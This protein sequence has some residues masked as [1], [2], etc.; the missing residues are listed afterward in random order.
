M[1]ARLPWLRAVQFLLSAVLLTSPVALQAQG[2]TTSSLNG[3]VTSTEGAA[4]AEAI[5]VAVHLP[6]GTVYRATARTGGAYSIPNM[7]VGGPYKVTV[8]SIGFEPKVEDNVFLS[9]G[10]AFRLDFRMIRRAVQLA[11]LTT[12]AVRD[13]VLNAGRSGATTFIDPTKVALLPSIKR[14]TRDLTRLDPRSD[15]NYSFAGRNWLYNNITLDGSYFNN[16]F[17]LDDPSP[18]GQ[19][20]AEPVPFDAIDQVHVSI[21]PFDVRQGG[22]TGANVNMVTKSG[23]NELHGTVS[24]FYRNDALQGNTVR[25]SSVIANPDLKYLQ[26]GFSA[27]GPIQRD[28]LFFFVAAELQRNRDPGSNFVASRGSTGF[29]IS[30]VQASVMDAIRQ[31][32]ITEYDYDPGPYEGYQFH[33]DNDKILAK[34]DWNL[35]ENTN[36]SFRYNYLSASRD[37]GPH[38][39]VLSVNNT[40]RGPNASSLPFYKSG[41]AI[42]NKLNSFALELNSRSTRYANRFFASYNRFRDFRSP[43]SE[44]F[45]T[46][47]I[48]EAGVT[49]TTAGSEPFSIHN[50]LD[51]DVFQVTN[52]FTVFR[53]KHTLTFG[54]NFEQFKFFNSFNIFRNGVFFLPQFIPVGSTFSSVSEFFS[55]TAPGPNQKDFRG[56]IGSGPFKGEKISVG[57]LS[58]YVEDELP[59]SARLN[60][61]FG[62]RV[63]LPM[64]FTDPVDNAYTR[65]LTALDENRQPETVDQ[66]RLPGTKAL[67]SP[68]IG[69]NWNAAG[70]RSTQIRGGTGIFTGR[71]PFVWVGNVISNP[72]ANPLL[73]PTGPQIITGKNTTLAQSFDINA[74]DPNF[75]YPQSWTTDLAI[76]QRLP[77]QF[78]GTLEVIY[79]KDLNGVFMRNANLRAPVR[80]LPDGRPYYSDASGNNALN[81]LG[82]GGIYVIDNTNKGH[83]FNATAQLRKTFGAALN[84]TLAYSFTDAKNTLKSTEIASVLWQNQPVQG[85]PNNP[86]LSYSE[87]GQRHRIVG[88]ATWS[89]AWSTRFRTSVGAFLEVG[90]GNRFSGSGGNRYS[91]IYAGDVNGD[92]QGGNDL[93]YIPRTQ[94]D[95]NLAN[96]AQW[97]ALDAFISQDKYLNAHRGEISQRFGETNPW[98]SNVD[99][100]VM[101]DFAFAGGS[102]VHNF[103]LSV[104]ILNVGNLLKSSWGVRKVADAAATSPLSLTGFTTA[105]APIFSFSG[106][107]KTFI[108]DPS[109]FSRWQMQIGLRYFIQ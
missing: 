91:F 20:N 24:A 53:G 101:Q 26:S 49:Y 81:N 71:V 17:G 100:R 14:S 41:Y 43:F 108:D 33:T 30:R 96:P 31:R 34:L 22:F 104:D 59:A 21:A 51:Q 78:L 44:D 93:I 38:P 86:E 57:Q 68:R 77:G 107:T 15:G 11:E 12:T 56:M 32:L 99:L 84:T 35:K 46:V 65:G 25:G 60:L 36:L 66:S 63:D 7:R 74:M 76:D 62:A 79:G 13:E 89:R 92:G 90:Q 95:I 42:N 3:L 94:A 8:T 103:Q 109:L 82:G 61:T 102:K 40:G 106:A 80:T 54:A 75:K 9:L 1:N 72:G 52:D 16:S 18:G 64:Y 97:A 88:S 73:F 4:P 28:K 39:F 98:Y 2:V 58:F 69:F 55:A 5:V 10:Q 85:D 105:G 29:G 19:S 50:I 70:D 47:E 83:S 45:P 27:G 23:T 48:G 67:L 87:F 6:S 37:Q